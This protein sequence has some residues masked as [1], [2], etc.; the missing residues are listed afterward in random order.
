[1]EVEDGFRMPADMKEAG[2]KV[3]YKW[4]NEV[5]KGTR[6]DGRYFI[7]INPIPNQ[8]LSLDNPST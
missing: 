5:W 2:G 6:I 7:D 4:V 1:M 3:E 8:R